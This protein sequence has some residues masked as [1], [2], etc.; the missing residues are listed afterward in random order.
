MDYKKY[1]ESVERKSEILCFAALGTSMA[2]I[3]IGKALQTDG[4][5]LVTVGASILLIMSLWWPYLRM[6]KVMKTKD[7]EN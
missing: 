7:N 5:T 4:Y 6:W 1:A 3:L 2:L